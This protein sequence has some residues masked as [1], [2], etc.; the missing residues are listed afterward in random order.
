MRL[1]YP[2]NDPTEQPSMR[3]PY[4]TNDDSSA[5]ILDKDIDQNNLYKSTNILRYQ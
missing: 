4:K 5:E 3:L 2:K 1:P